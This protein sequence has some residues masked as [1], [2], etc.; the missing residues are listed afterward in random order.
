MR[1]GWHSATI[2]T[3][4]YQ[5]AGWIPAS[6]TRFAGIGVDTFRLRRAPASGGDS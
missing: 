1:L 4:G 6:D 3:F 5:T 2:C